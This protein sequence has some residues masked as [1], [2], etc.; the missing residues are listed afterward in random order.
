MARKKAPNPRVPGERKAKGV[1]S[2]LADTFE[3]ILRL[4]APDIQ[5]TR[6]YRFHPTRGWRFDFMLVDRLAL[7]IDGG[8]R[9]ANGGRHN[10]DED[11]E[12]LN[13]AAAL[14]WCVIRF[15]TTM[16]DRNPMGCIEVIRK[17]VAFQATG[18]VL[19]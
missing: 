16:I 14:G 2:D 12:K 18:L 19:K 17:A 15:S 11:R 5:Y 8:Q 10:S 13:E 1:R 6:E 4:L 7:E 9:C 3:R